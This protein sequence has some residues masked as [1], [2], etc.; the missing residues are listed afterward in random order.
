MRVR[1][2]LLVVDGE[3]PERACSIRAVAARCAALLG[4]DRFGLP[5]LRG[6]GEAARA[7]LAAAFFFAAAAASILFVAAICAGLRFAFF[8]R[9]FLAMR[10]G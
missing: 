8:G 4:F 6:A 2:V 7:G 9:I 1:L 10:C 3:F 5:L